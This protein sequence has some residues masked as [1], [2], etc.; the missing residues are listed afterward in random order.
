MGALAIPKAMVATPKNAHLCARL[1][2]KLNGVDLGK[3]VIAY[4][5][6]EGTVELRS[7]ETKRGVVEA[8]W[9]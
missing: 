4:S 8:Y 3:S 7:G 6:P 5:I 2:V 9:R 1:G